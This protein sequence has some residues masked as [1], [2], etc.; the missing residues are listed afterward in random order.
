MRFDLKK[1]P[2][3]SE[4]QTQIDEYEKKLSD[5]SLPELKAEYQRAELVKLRFGKPEY[6]LSESELVEKG[7]FEE[8]LSKLPPS[9]LVHYESA[10]EDETVKNLVEA[11]RFRALTPELR[12]FYFGEPPEYVDWGALDCW[13]I[14]EATS[15]T[16][17]LDP[18]VDLFSEMKEPREVFAAGRSS[19]SVEQARH[20]LKVKREELWKEIS[21]RGFPTDPLLQSD[22]DDPETVLRECPL[23]I[24]Q[25]MYLA[26]MIFSPIFPA[27]MALF[28]LSCSRMYSATASG[29][30][31]SQLT[32]FGLAEYPGN[33]IRPTVGF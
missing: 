1:K 3:T 13:T 19:S 22:A 2:M 15:L 14:D 5:F 26:G 4:Y 9:E 33:R 28:I 16:M 12:A 8:R 27:S 18:K 31:K 24:A 29:T 23:F 10:S 6:A 11:H 20:A 25:S 17:G 21:V 7:H 30:R 32:E